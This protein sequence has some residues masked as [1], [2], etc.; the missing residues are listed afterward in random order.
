MGND[1]CANYRIAK[2]FGTVTSLSDEPAFEPPGSFNKAGPNNGV[3][4]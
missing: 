4:E 2:M 3:S 1:V